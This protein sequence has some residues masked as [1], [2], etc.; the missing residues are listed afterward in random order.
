MYLKYLLKVFHALKAVGET[1]LFI[2]CVFRE[3]IFTITHEEL[4]N[5]LPIVTIKGVL[6]WV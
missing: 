1:L 4:I 3:W 6:I 2:L 5:F